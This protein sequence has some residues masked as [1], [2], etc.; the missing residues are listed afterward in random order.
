MF[1]SETRAFS[2][3]SAFLGLVL[4]S[5]NSHS[6]FLLVGLLVLLASWCSTTL[7]E[8]VLGPSGHVLHVLHAASAWGTSALGLLA[9]LV[10]SD[11]GSRVAAGCALLVLNVVGALAAPR[12][13]GV[14]LLVALAHCWSTVSHGFKVIALRGNNDRRLQ[15]CPYA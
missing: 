7:T 4:H 13:H 11:L 1:S 2:T 3:Y 6:L 10:R 8:A 5:L 14:C 15:V 9:P 12:A